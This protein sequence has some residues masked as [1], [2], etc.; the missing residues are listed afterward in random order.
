MSHLCTILYT[1][2][3]ILYIQ[4]HSI[5]VYAM[6][7]SSPM[8]QHHE[9]AETKNIKI[10]LNNFEKRKRCHLL[11]LWLKV[12]MDGVGLLDSAMG[13]LH[14]FCARSCTLS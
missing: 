4:R 2:L 13:V 11:C 14:V 12:H 10:K 8:L 6:F 9:P 1:I 7:I 3:C 5:S